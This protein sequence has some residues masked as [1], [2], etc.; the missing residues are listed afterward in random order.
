MQTLLQIILTFVWIFAVQAEVPEQTV[1]ELVR[2]IRAELPRGWSASYEKETSGVR[3]ERGEKVP[4]VFAVMNGPA[5]EKSKPSAF[6]FTYRINPFLLVDEFGRLRAENEKIQKEVT[7][8]YDQLVKR[9]VSQKFDDFLPVNE[10][11]KK[12]VARYEALK[13]SLHLLPD[14]HFRDISVSWSYNGPGWPSIYVTDDRAREECSRVKVS[15]V[16]LLSKYDAK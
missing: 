12:L 7:V 9:H 4:A 13:S 8:L 16:K 14:F 15:V 10:E 3:V 6:V 2:A 11:D 5:G 1:T